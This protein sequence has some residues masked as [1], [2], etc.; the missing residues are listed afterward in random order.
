[1]PKN[2]K[3]PNHNLNPASA[4]S[5]KPYDKPNHAAT[6][7]PY[8]SGAGAAGSS[9]L[10]A[11]NTSIGQHF[12]KN[13]AVITSII[14]KAGVKPTDVVLEI[15]PGTGTFGMLPFANCSLHQQSNLS[16]NLIFFVVT[17]GT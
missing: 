4:A 9:N 6:G 16:T 17:Q 11:P 7:A 5:R 2:A 8:A 12:L 13:P 15:G 10:V 3:R 1:M 14:E